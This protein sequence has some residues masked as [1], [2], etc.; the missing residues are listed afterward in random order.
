MMTYTIRSICTGYQLLDK[1][2]YGT[3]RRGRGEIIEHPVF[4]FLIEGGGRKVLVPV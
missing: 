1:G 2:W 4:A 3:F